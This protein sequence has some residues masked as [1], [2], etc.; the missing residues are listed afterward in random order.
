MAHA[1]QSCTID[2]AERELLPEFGAGRIIGCGHFSPS[3]TIRVMPRTVLVTSCVAGAGK[4]TISACRG[5][6]SV[7][8]GQ[9]M[10]VDADRQRAPRPSMTAPKVL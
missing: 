7:S 5:I 4:T 2:H 10:L 8:S 3:A 1:V 6:A 9:K